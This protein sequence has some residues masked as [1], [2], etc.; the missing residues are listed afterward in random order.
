M[1]IVTKYSNRNL[2]NYV[3]GDV[4]KYKFTN[5]NEVVFYTSDGKE[6]GRELLK[7]TNEKQKFEPIKTIVLNDKVI[8]NDENSEKFKRGVKW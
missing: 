6:I 7:R 3:I 2:R 8:Y 5:E 1:L 4:E